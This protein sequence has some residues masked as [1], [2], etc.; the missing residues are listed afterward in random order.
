MATALTL[1]VEAVVYPAQSYSGQQVAVTYTIPD[2]AQ[3][4][5]LSAARSAWQTTSVGGGASGHDVVSVLAQTSLDGG[6]TWPHTIGFNACGGNLLSP[7]AT[8]VTS[9]SVTAPLPSGTGRQVR[10]SMNCFV[11][12]NVQLTATVN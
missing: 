5:T 8:A 1:A 6:V 10:I 4:L 9:S 11:A 12:I 2:G 7:T 3:S